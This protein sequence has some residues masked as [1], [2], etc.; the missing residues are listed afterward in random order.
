MSLPDYYATLGVPSGATPEQIERAYKRLVS[1]CH[2]DL[3]G[4]DPARD[5]THR[6][7][8]R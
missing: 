5:R 2:P 4:N 6:A 8:G 1:I 3:F 7:D